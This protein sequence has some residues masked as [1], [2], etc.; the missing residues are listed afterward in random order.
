MDRPRLA[1]VTSAEPLPSRPENTTPRPCIATN[2]RLR[3]NLTW[4]WARSSS[5]AGA[6]HEVSS[7][8]AAVEHVETTTAPA[9]SVVGQ[10]ATVA[11]AF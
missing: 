11:V 1:P 9:A 3:E 10:P 7:G 5:G 2:R 6:E 4:L 8:A